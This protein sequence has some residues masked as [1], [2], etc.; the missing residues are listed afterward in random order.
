MLIVNKAL[1][2]TV[3]SI[4]VF[5]AELPLIYIWQLLEWLSSYFIHRYIY[6]RDGA[7]EE[8]TLFILTSGI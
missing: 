5:G 1:I 6:Q 7:N 8:Q 2:S 3:M 4:M